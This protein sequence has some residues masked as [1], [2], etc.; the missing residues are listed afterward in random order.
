MIILFDY[1]PYFLSPPAAMWHGL[2]ILAQNRISR[3]RTPGLIPI[4][5][6]DIT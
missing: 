4:F 5:G 3:L 2:A 1:I 6:K